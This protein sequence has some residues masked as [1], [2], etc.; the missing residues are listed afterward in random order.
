[1]SSYLLG[2]LLTTFDSHMLQPLRLSR[3][4]LH[5]KHETFLSYRNPNL[6]AKFI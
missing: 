5:N 4:F 2:S 3:H 1:M 6:F